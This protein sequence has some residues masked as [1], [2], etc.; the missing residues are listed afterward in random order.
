VT[1]MNIQGFKDSVDL[2]SADLSKWPPEQVKPAIAFMR[3]NSVAADY[4]DKALLLDAKLRVYE[5]ETF[6]AA[7][8]EAR[9]MQG[10]TGEKQAEKAPVEA[11]IAAKAVEKQGIEKPMR[12]AWLFAPAG[13]LMAIALLGFFFGFSQPQQQ[14]YSPL[15]PAYVAEEKMASIDADNND[16][17]DGEI[18]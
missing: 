6:D 14:A 15:D 2:Y 13:G 1:E 10:I 4:F 11:V 5:P 18:F 17:Y 3:D 8:L 16:G 7:A 12:A 9:I